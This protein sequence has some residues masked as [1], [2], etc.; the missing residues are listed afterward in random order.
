MSL[1]ICPNKCYLTCL[2]KYKNMY[3]YNVVDDY[4]LAW[5]QENLTGE[6]GK[7]S[8]GLKDKGN[9]RLWK[10]QNILCLGVR[11]DLVKNATRLPHG[12]LG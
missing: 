6:C 2:L 5:F 4:L 11:S 8:K 9:Y 12:W 10:I 7:K 1:D 3:G